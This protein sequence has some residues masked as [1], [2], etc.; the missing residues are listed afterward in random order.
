MALLYRACLKIGEI[1]TGLGLLTAIKRWRP[2][3]RGQV[4]VLNCQNP[5]T[6]I[7]IIRSTRLDELP[8]GLAHKEL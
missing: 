3:V 4:S 1:V 7:T 8:R 6:T 5:E 2:R